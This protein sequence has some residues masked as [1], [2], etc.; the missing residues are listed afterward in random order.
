MS[1]LKKSSRHILLSEARAVQDG[2]MKIQKRESIFQNQKR[3]DSD[4][5]SIN[6]VNC[7][8]KLYFWRCHSST[9]LIRQ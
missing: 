4:P 2:I 1:R 3:N 5:E 9:N 6:S 8:G 7:L